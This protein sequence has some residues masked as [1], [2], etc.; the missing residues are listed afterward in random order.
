M[1][2]LSPREQLAQDRLAKR[3]GTI[4]LALL[5]VMGVI[6]VVSL[7]MRRG[8]EGGDE[9]QASIAL[10]SMEEEKIVRVGIQAGHWK[11]R[12]VPSE[13]DKLRRNGG[14][15]S[16]AGVDEWEINLAVAEKAAAILA[17]QDIMVDILPTA[18]DPG[19]EADAFVAIHAD[20]NDDTSV[21][22]YKV[23]ASSFDKSGL[24]EILSDTIEETYGTAITMRHDPSTSLDM[25]EYY[26]FNYVKYE[27]SIAPTTPGALVE[28]GFLTHDGDRSILVNKTDR[29]AK[30]VADGILAFLREQGKI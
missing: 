8:S 14:G 24:A 18:V 27:H 9:A 21:S 11:Y 20:G 26:A 22:G 5:F 25:T 3:K 23:E 13:L 10:A 19:Y 15:A 17:R 12:E 4:A 2:L 28:V 16:V 29:V 1:T 7:S 30:A 6:G